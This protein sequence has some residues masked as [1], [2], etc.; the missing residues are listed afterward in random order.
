MDIQHILAPGP[1][2]VA[3]PVLPDSAPPAYIS[4]P[5]NMVSIPSLPVL[6]PAPISTSTAS[7]SMAFPPLSLSSMAMSSSQ[8]FQLPLP[9]HANRNALTFVQP[10]RQLAQTSN[11]QKASL[12]IRQEANE[13]DHKE[14]NTELT[15]LLVKH[16]LELT[17]LAGR[18]GKKF[19]YID[20][21]VGTS[22]HYKAK[23]G[24]SIENAKLHAKAMEVNA[25]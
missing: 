5:G 19:D 16:R 15:A 10:S 11:A 8:F 9:T 7:T 12:K 3:S 21:L 23:R 25:G 17:D 13:A 18:H 2:L 6:I 22:K 14:L 4:A 20:K 24:V 1:P